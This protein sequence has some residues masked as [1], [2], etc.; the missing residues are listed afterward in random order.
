MQ[1]ARDLVLLDV[2]LVENLLVVLREFVPLRA[3][4]TVDNPDVVL[5]LVGALEVA[6]GN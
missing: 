3:Q 4:L 1:T 5:D 2:D 6:T